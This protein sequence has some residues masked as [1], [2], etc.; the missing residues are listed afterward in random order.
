MVDSPLAYYFV[1]KVC[2]TLEKDKKNNVFFFFSDKNLRHFTTIIKDDKF[3]M[4]IVLPLRKAS[5][6]KMIQERHNNQRDINLTVLEK[7]KTI[8]CENYQHG[9]LKVSSKS[10]NYFLINF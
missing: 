1:K 6:R 2:K 4:A 10:N 8:V 5:L 3:Y 9:D 7:L